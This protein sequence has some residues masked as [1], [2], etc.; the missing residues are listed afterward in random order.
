MWIFAQNEQGLSIRNSIVLLRASGMLQNTF[1]TKSRK[2][3]L[4]AVVHFIHK[5]NY[6]YSQKKN[7]ATNAL[8]EVYKEAW[9]FFKFTHP[10]LLGPHCNRHLIFNMEQKPLHSPYHSSKTLEKCGTKTIHI[11]KMLNGT[12]RAT[13][14][15]AIAAAGD[16]LTPMIIF[17]NTLVGGLKKRTAQI[18]P[19]FH[20]HLPG[21]CV[22]G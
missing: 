22:D 5:H 17:K 21:S 8:Q 9:E 19:F 3:W 11:C 12:T 10:L 1:S 16:C 18:Q 20:L 6:I 13:R 15:F 14:A 2:A 4:K 7:K